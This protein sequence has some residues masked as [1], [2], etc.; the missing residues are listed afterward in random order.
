MVPA[1]PVRIGLD[2]GQLVLAQDGRRH[3][4]V[5]GELEIG[6]SGRKDRRPSKGGTH[7]HRH[8][9]DLLFLLDQLE[10][11]V[12]DIDPQISPAERLGQPAPALEVDLDLPDALFHRNIES[13][14]GPGPDNPVRRQTVPPLKQAHRLLRR[15][16][17]PLPLRLPGNFQIAAQH[18][19]AAQQRQARVVASGPQHRSGRNDGPSPQGRAPPILLQRLPQPQ[20]ARVR[21]HQ[22][23]EHLGQPAVVQGEGKKPGQ[24]RLARPG[25]PADMYFFRID[26][27]LHQMIGIEQEGVGEKQI[28]AGHVR[29][30][31][32]HSVPAV[33]GLQCDQRLDR[34]EMVVV[35]AEPLAA[36]A[37]QDIEHPHGRGV[38]AEVT[39]PCRKVVPLPVKAGQQLTVEQDRLPQ[40]DL[41]R[42]RLI[43]NGPDLPGDLNAQGLGG[44]RLRQSEANHG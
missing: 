2:Q 15:R 9:Q 40:F 6:H 34:F 16:I 32:E 12:G 44:R 29:H 8:R 30:V 33:I 41:R 31:V 7:H 18:Q 24:V 25:P 28:E 27:P 37:S 14:Q 10:T 20:V 4:P 22:A 5:R 42:L 19:P 26:P 13:R 1:H 3:V 43:E 35:A 23:V 39:D 21:R 36:G 17:V 11:E 38:D